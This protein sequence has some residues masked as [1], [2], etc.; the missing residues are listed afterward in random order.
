MEQ[1]HCAVLAGKARQPDREDIAWMQSWEVW[2]RGRAK[3]RG[4]EVKLCGFAVL[5]GSDDGTMKVE[6]WSSDGV[7]CLQARHDSQIEKT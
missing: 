2:Q 3:R 4:W 7:Q 6:L 1:C 5:V